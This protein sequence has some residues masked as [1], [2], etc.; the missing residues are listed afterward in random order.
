MIV[1]AEYAEIWRFG[2]LTEIVGDES[3][4][5]EELKKLNIDGYNIEISKKDSYGITGTYVNVIVDGEDEYGH[6]HSV[7]EGDHQHGHEH[8]HEDEHH[9]HEHHHEHR[10][11]EDVKKIIDDSKLDER[12]KSLAKEIF[13]KVAKAESKVHGK[14]IGEVHFHEVGAIDSII[15]IVG[16]A[17]FINKR[18]HV[19]IQ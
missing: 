12:T 18:F 1:Q 8:H 5:I 11:L 14:P 15:D 13:L 17:I 16:T 19:R 9:H 7:H 3:Y 6:V 4:L 2:S 10:N